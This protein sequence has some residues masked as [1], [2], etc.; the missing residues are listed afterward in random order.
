[1]CS[2]CCNKNLRSHA[3]I[4]QP[5][6]IKQKEPSQNYISLQNKHSGCLYMVNGHL[7]FQVYMGPCDCKEMSFYSHVKGDMR[8]FVSLCPPV[9]TRTGDL[10]LGA[11]KI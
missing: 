1:M 5:R 7:I 2:E 4:N 10:P 6:K 11:A 9:L 3:E 8:A